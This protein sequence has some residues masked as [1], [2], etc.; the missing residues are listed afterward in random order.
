MAK[1]HKNVN[2]PRTF[3]QQCYASLENV[4]TLWIESIFHTID[5]TTNNSRTINSK[6]KKKIP[7]QRWNRFLIETILSPKTN[8]QKKKKNKHTISR[9]SIPG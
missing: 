2:H 1:F 4:Q 7:L 9:I 8:R 3:E 5:Q 6:K